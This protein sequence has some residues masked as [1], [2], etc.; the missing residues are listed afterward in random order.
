MTASLAAA[1]AAV[2][3]DAAPAPLITSDDCCSLG[4][5]AFGKA[6]WPTVLIEPRG[7][8]Q[9]DSTD[10]GR[11]HMN[12]LQQEAEAILQSLFMSSGR[13]AER[14]ITPGLTVIDDDGDEEGVW[15]QHD[16]ASFQQEA[17]P[18]LP[19]VVRPPV[20]QSVPPPPVRLVEEAV[21]GQADP[22]PCPP[23][24]A[25]PREEGMG[26][27]MDWGL[28][29]QAEGVLRGVAPGGTRVILERQA[30]GTASD[31]AFSAEIV[32]RCLSPVLCMSFEMLHSV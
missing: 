11:H 23:S 18:C 21:E 19:S 2:A 8:L 1:A 31:K 13:G 29:S 30:G 4:D 22:E 27:V 6:L 15:Q 5:A 14:G 32:R 20:Q 7:G 24:H 10:S 25:P 3:A 17:W 16:H 28:S 9:D 12:A 26:D